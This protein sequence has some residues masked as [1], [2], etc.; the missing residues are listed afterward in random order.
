MNLIS[1]AQVEFPQL[2]PVIPLAAFTNPWML[3]WGAAAAVPI[4]LHLWKRRQQL[5][6][7]WAAMRFLVAALE[8]HTKRLRFEQLILLTVRV[9][10]LLLFVL[11]VANPVVERDGSGR[12]SDRSHAILVLD[13]SYSMLYESD[14]ESRFARARQLANELIERS[15]PGRAFAVL[16]LADPP[17]VIVGTPTFEHAAVAAEIAKMEAAPVGAK[18]LPALS[19]I[20]RILDETND[21]Q[22]SPAQV[23][24]FSDLQRSTWQ[25]ATSEECRVKLE[26]LAAR[27]NLTIV[28]VGD[29]T[30]EN[31]AVTALQ[32]LEALPAIG[33]PF[34]FLATIR[35]FGEKPQ[36][37]LPVEL[38]VDGQ[39]VDR[40]SVDVPPQAGTTAAFGHR[41]GVDGQHR[42]EVRIAAADGLAI[43]DRRFLAVNVHET[44]NV[45]CV[46]G[47]HE[48]ARYLALALRAGTAS[49]T[50]IRVREGLENDLLVANVNALDALFLC[51]VARFSADESRILSNFVK[52]GGGLAIFMGDQV[53]PENYNRRIGVAAGPQ[54]IL[55]VRIGG[56]ES[57][58]DIGLD[59]RAYEHPI[60]RPFRGHEKAGLLSTPIWSYSRLQLIASANPQV[61][62]W[63]GQ[64]P[65]IVSAEVGSGRVIVVATAASPLSLDRNQDPPVPWTA[66]A[67]WPSYPPVVH[68]MLKYLVGGQRHDRQV[69]A[70]EPLTAALPQTPSPSG[71]T[72][73]YG[74]A[75]GQ[76]VQGSLVD[77]RY[78]WSFDDTFRTGFFTASYDDPALEDEI[79]AVNVGTLESDLTRLAAAQIPPELQLE[80]AVLQDA[81]QLLTLGVGQQSY[82]RWLLFPVLGLLLLEV[83]LVWLFA[84]GLV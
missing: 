6:T 69:L 62:L 74:D 51:N 58:M 16:T 53:Q 23:Y 31:L 19:H 25:E 18:L 21:G 72:I 24:F 37:A 12:L 10:T 54:A 49:E 64:N 52:N 65:G 9:L 38:V 5:D 34:E 36:L 81:G 11:A 28:D 30:G 56:V 84:R 60:I 48:S 33:S 8:K 22:A 17:Q 75:S 55:P 2:P 13:A 40:R 57:G 70:G 26:Q 35:N 83:F 7:P 41:F 82:V 59:P 44:I 27:S 39:I 1:A 47:K 46:H 20:E 76:R 43:D 73:S 77:N 4:V 14:G 80:T 63:F 78:T 3:L 29:R 67:T 66:W 61:G 71:L 15:G 45:L 79:F 42:V 32:Q 50:A 68:E